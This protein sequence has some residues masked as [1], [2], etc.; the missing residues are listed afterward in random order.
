MSVSKYRLIVLNN[1]AEITPTA[2][3]GKIF[4]RSSMPCLYRKQQPIS[5]VGIKNSKFMLRATAYSVCSTTVSHSISKLPPPTPSP[6]KKPNTVPAATATGKLF[7]I[8]NGYLPT[9]S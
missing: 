2:I 3:A 1:A 5:A 7:N 8:Y 4:L 9:G 6:A